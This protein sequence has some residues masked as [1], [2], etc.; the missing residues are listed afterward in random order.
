MKKLT[1]WATMTAMLTL[2]VGLMLGTAASPVDANQMVSAAPNGVYGIYSIDACRDSTTVTVSGS[3]EFATN[4]IV[5]SVSYLND[6]GKY[7][8]LQQTT[9]GNFGSGSFTI[10]VTI[11]Y[12]A[13]PVDEGTSLQVIVQ[14]QG[15][16]GNGFVNLGDS[17][18]TYVTAADK[19]CEGKCSVVLSTT[20]RAPANGVVTL[21]T[22][23]GSW[24]RPEGWWQGAIP[25]YA[26]QAVQAT[27][28]GAPCGAQGRAWFYPATGKDRTPKMLP[29]QLWPDEFGTS[30]SGGSS[31]YVTSFAK[32]LPATKPLEPDDPYAPK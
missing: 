29:S 26:G 6:K 4:Q 9:S 1:S 13:N 18:T 11:D 3:S 32:G 10:P 14:L 2:V 16:T 27:I 17:V 15:M 8:L 12:S 20:D 31:F 5:A 28:A 24:F 25:V 7:I 19:F 22:H 21:R 30:S 23:F